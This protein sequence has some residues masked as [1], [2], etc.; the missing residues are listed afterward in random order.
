MSNIRRNKNDIFNLRLSR[1]NY[2]DLQLSQE[3]IQCYNCNG[4][5]SGDVVAT[6][7]FNNVSGMCSEVIWSEA[8]SFSGDI[9][10]IGLTGVDNRFVDNFSGETF[11]PSGDTH[12]CVKRVSGDTFCYDMNYVSATGDSPE[13]VQFCGGF[14]QG[15]YKL[16]EY[17]YQ[18]L[19][20]FYPE[21]WTKEFW[22]KQESCPTGDVVTITGENIFYEPASSGYTIV[23]EIWEMDVISGGTCEEKPSLNEVYPENE[24]IFYFWGLRAENK[25]CLFNPFSGLTTCT[26]VPL[27]P[28]FEIK[29]FEPEINPFLYYNRRQLCK[30]QP[31]PTVEFTDCCDG[32]LNNAMAFRVTDEGEVGVRLLTTTG[33]CVC[34]DDTIKFSG[35]PIIE[36]YYSSEGIIREDVWHHVV[37]K[38]EPYEKTECVG[39]R[40]GFGVLSVYVD[41]YLKFKVDDFPEFMPYA[42]CEHRDKQLGVPYNI[43]LGGG[44][45]GLLES[46]PTG[47]STSF[48]V[49]GTTVCDYVTNLVE[50]CEFGG[51]SINGELFLSPPLSVK[52]PEL[53]QMWLEMTIPRR[54]GK[55][56]VK[57]QQFN[58]RN[59]LRIELHGIIDKIDHMLYANKGGILGVCQTGCYD[60]PA[61][62]GTCGVL[63]DNFAGTFIGGIAEYRLHDRPLCFSEIQCNF[64]QESEKYNKTREISPCAR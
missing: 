19:P 31:N 4:I 24:G 28:E 29:E 46:I 26:G 63:E 20:N 44:T 50:P 49:S 5:V 2:W 18:T 33:E 7:D 54:F 17:E 64:R 13:Y 10:D 41:G 55:I 22:I 37:F 15:F 47:D 8:V 45:Q 48:D 61:H 60:L 9:C 51:I 27:A 11:N 23:S 14:F 53:I 34:V 42:L 52:E 6:F 57:G 30:P 1:K 32:L 3:N 35:T 40:I 58:R 56:L 36:E 39:Y 12:F 16:H 25:F 62:A 38:F 21:G 59:A 43:S